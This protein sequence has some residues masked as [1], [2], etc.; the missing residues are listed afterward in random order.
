MKQE[1]RLITEQ[2]LKNYGFVYKEKLGFWY[3]HILFPWSY[4]GMIFRYRYDKKELETQRHN[5]IGA[6]DIE[7]HNEEVGYKLINEYAKEGLFHKQ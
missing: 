3:R 1:E 5:I 2:F 7:Y 6:E 4:D